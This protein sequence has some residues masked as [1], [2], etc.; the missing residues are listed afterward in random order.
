MDT[1]ASS[2]IINPTS[3][4]EERHSCVFSI[5]SDY[6]LTYFDRVFEKW[7]WK[8]SQRIPEK[9]D[10]LD[11]LLSKE[12]FEKVKSICEGLIKGQTL[13]AGSSYNLAPIFDDKQKISGFT[14]FKSLEKPFVDFS[15]FEKLFQSSNELLC[16]ANFDGFL[17]ELNKAWENQLGH[18]LEYIRSMPFVEFVHPEDVERTIEESKALADFKDSVVNFEN[19][20]RTKQGDYKWIQ[21]HAVS[22]KETQLIYC[23]CRDVTQVKELEKKNTDLFENTPAMMHYLN[24][25]GNIIDVNKKWLD[26]L[27]Y[28]KAEVVGKK[29]SDFITETCKNYAEKEVIPQIFS[30]GFIVDAPYDFIKKNGERLPTR[31]SAFLYQDQLTK[32]N[33]SISVIIPVDEL[34]ES[35]YNLEKSQFNFEMASILGNV[36]LWDWDFTKDEVNYSDQWFKQL[37]Y[38]PSELANTFDTFI[39]LLHQDDHLVA[40]KFI[41]KAQQNPMEQQKA[42]FRLKHKDGSYRWILSQGKVLTDTN[43]E[44]YRMVGSHVEITERKEA[45]ERF[46]SISQLASDYAYSVSVNKEGQFER[47]WEF[48]FVEGITGFKLEE[49]LHR[50]N[51]GF[52]YHPDDRE[53]IAER[54]QKLTRG[55]EVISEYR[56]KHKSGKYIFIRDRSVPTLCSRG[57]SLKKIVGFAEDISNEKALELAKRETEE[58]L[59]KAISLL[60]AVNE[61]ATIGTWEVNLETM[62][63]VWS[64]ITKEIHEV[65]EDYQADVGI[66]IEFYKEGINREIIT[67][68]VQKAMEDGTKFDVDL[69]IIT[70]KGNEKWVRA[71]GLPVFQDEKCIKL[72]GTFQDI[73]DSKVAQLEIEK[74]SLVA[75]HSHNSVVITDSEAKVLWANNAFYKM[76]GYFF[77]EVKGKKIGPIL[78]GK[79][80]DKAHTDKIRAGIRSKKPFTQIVKNYTKAGESYW[81][82]L[83]VTPILDKNNEVTKF[84]GIQVDAT[85]RIQAEQELK[86]TENQ[87]KTIAKSVPG[88]LLKYKLNP[89]YTDELL[90]ISD[91]V[92]ELWG[93]EKQEAMA[94]VSALWAQIHPDDVSKMQESIMNSAQNLSFWDIEYRLVAKNGETRWVNGRGFPHKESDGSVVWNTLIIDLTRLKQAESS[95]QLALEQKGTLLRELH[96]RIK[97]N[98]QLISSI[99]YLKSQEATSEVLKDFIQETD[100]RIKSIAQIHNQLLLLEENEDELDAGHYLSVLTESQ[101]YHLTESTEKYPTTIDVDHF[102]LN[103]DHVLAM[104]LIVNEAISN[105][106]KYAYPQEQGGK[107]DISLKIKS[108]KITLIIAD[109]GKSFD[110]HAMDHYK[111]LGLSLIQTLSQ[112]LKAALEVEADQGVRYTLTFNLKN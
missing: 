87:I 64:S 1:S 104:G 85:K 56:I 84:I 89:D 65:P 41:Q 81:N 97:N 76:T 19:R 109:Y 30:K 54:L 25:A 90:Y 26:N 20:Y 17:I 93:V 11:I 55:E 51:K 32:E 36:G 82:E 48:G 24:E 110:Y 34:V 47:D 5:S 74:L 100:A 63:A 62:T 68:K 91:A 40:E 49:L 70:A 10:A 99:F 58:D 102:K 96:H 4:K 44:P 27:G 28:T 92:K 80:T 16:I 77:E 72:H 43:D 73:T 67:E 42:E 6:H 69:E 50:I 59:Q 31:K 108:K 18:S 71:I 3:L 79:G 111:H 9:G 13:Q 53:V 78:Q 101:V 112:Q 86:K 106:I 88:V 66:A 103:I 75:S 57:R 15:P 33:Y 37:G 60:N 46:K 8:S 38:L 98:L 21:W 23:V 7:I 61:A 39:T 22:D 45:E 12:E 107:L 95:L 29:S 35:E 14:L 2:I 94:N 52:C 83:S 105:S